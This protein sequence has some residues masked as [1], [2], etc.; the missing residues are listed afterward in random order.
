MLVLRMQDKRFESEE[1][2]FC[3]W[4]KILN[5]ADKTLDEFFSHIY[6]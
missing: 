3:V 5:V 1:Y 2:L 4:F 6:R